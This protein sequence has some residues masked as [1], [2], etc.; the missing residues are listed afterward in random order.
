VVE[1]VSARRRLLAVPRVD[2]EFAVEVLTEAGPVHVTAFPD[3]WCESAL[4]FD[5]DV[6]HSEELVEIASLVVVLTSMLHS[7][8]AQ[9]P[10]PS[11][12]RFAHV[13][14]YPYSLAASSPRL[15]L[16]GNECESLR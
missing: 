8:L 12:Y 3:C 4:P 9:T 1:T 13:L 11:W 5:W 2:V 16:K 14:V 6:W 7:A 10:S 15:N